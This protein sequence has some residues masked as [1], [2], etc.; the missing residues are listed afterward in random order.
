M[1]LEKLKI[2]FPENYSKLPLDNYSKWNEIEK[3]LGVNLPTDYKEFIDLFGAGIIDDFI[4]VF[5]PFSENENMNFFIQQDLN[6]EAYSTLKESHPNEFPYQIFTK[7]SG[8]LPWGRTE[9]G[10]ILNWI[11]DMNLDEWPILIYDGYGDYFECQNS[12]T[13]FINDLIT[14]NISCPFFPG[15]FQNIEKHTFVAVKD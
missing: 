2:L 14:R 3:K 7:K 15:D 5:S 10:D 8:L 4:L 13:N 1:S 9:N 12:M 6:N 11:V